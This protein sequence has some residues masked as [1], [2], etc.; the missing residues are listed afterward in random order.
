M[1]RRIQTLE[2]Q[3]AKARNQNDDE[4]IR[5]LEG[6]KADLVLQKARLRMSA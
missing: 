4:R 3:I 5:V 2:Q 6:Q 1:E